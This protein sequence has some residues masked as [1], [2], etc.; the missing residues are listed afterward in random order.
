MPNS[1][2][3]GSIIIDTQLDTQGFEANSAELGKAIGSL[4]SQVD[5]LGP[6]FAQSLNGGVGSIQKFKDK[7]DGLKGTVS[8]LETE[9][10]A[11][12]NTRIPTD[13]Y[14]FIQ[15]QINKIDQ[16]LEKLQE[17]QAK[18]EATGVKQSSAA[19]KNLQYEIDLAKQKLDTYRSDAA[20]LENTGQAYKMGSDT[21]EYQQMADKLNQAKSALNEMNGAG[22][23]MHS[24]FTRVVS[25]FKQG[26]NVA[27][28][29]GSAMLRVGRTIGGAIHKG[30]SALVS[31]FKNMKTEVDGTRKKLLKMGL[32]LLG[33]RGLATGIR[34]IVN[35]ALN[36]NE[37][38]KNQLTALKGV[39]GQALSPA[40]SFLVGLLSKVVTLA[41][42]VYQIFTGTSLIAKYN[43]TQTK[44]AADGMADT[45]K[46]A[47]KA[48]RQLASF[49]SLNVLS[50]SNDSSKSSGGSSNDSESTP[51]KASKIKLNES[52]RDFFKALKKAIKKSDW[53]AVGALVA[54]GLNKALRKINW[55]K[56]KKTCKRIATKI[57]DFINAFVKKLDWGL[58]GKII[59]KAINTITVFVNTLAVKINWSRIGKSIAT[60]FK[61]MLNSINWELLGSTLASC[62]NIP[63]RIAENFAYTFNWGKFGKSIAST[64]RA[65][66][67][68]IDLQG[69][70]KA[71]TTGL[72]GIAKASQKLFTSP[73][74]TELGTKL[75][76][77][78]IIFFNNNPFGTVI[79]I[80]KNAL[81]GLMDAAIA[82]FKGGEV[83]EKFG[84]SVANGI[85]E[86]FCDGE[87]W[88][89]VGNLLSEVAKTVTKFAIAVI[90]N[91]NLKD[92][93]SAIAELLTNIDWWN[94]GAKIG[95]LIA[96]AILS[97][98]LAPA[99]WTG[100]IDD[101]TWKQWMSNLE[102][103]DDAKEQLFD[104]EKK[105]TIG[106]GSVDKNSFNVVNKILKKTKVS[107]QV[108]E[109]A[110]KKS[111][112]TV[113]SFREEL[114]KNKVS[115]ETMNKAL[116]ASGYS[117]KQVTSI[118]KNG[119]KEQKKALF[120]GLAS[121]KA[122]VVEGVKKT[123]KEIDKGIRIA[124]QKAKSGGKS[125]SKAAVDSANTELKSGK[126]TLT[127][128]T[129]ST[130]KTMISS[131]ISGAKSKKG[132]LKTSF[133]S[134]SDIANKA[135]GSA[136]F[137]TM[138]K[139]NVNK[140]VSGAKSVKGNVKSSF[141]SLSNIAN[142]A[143]G[144]APFGK[145]GTNAGNTFSTSVGST[146]DKAKSSGKDVGGNVI[147]G[148]IKGIEDA[149]DGFVKF[150]KEK[151]GGVINVAKTILGIHSPSTVFKAV[152]GFLMTGLKNG[153][154]GGAKS[155]VSSV[156]S[157]AGAITD[158]IKRGSYSITP[159][160]NNVGNVQLEMN[161]FTSV[162]SDGVTA[163]MDK[164]NYIAQHVTFRVPN[165]ALGTVVPYS[166]KGIPKGRNGGG[167]GGA[168]PY[169]DEELI[170][171]I[172]QAT[173]NQTTAII[174]ELQAQ[175][176]IPV[177]IDPKQMTTAVV[178][179]INRRTRATGKPQ[180]T[181]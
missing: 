136:P 14:K 162:I 82:L 12:G 122:F 157:V 2:A 167:Y 130:G 16:E 91:V 4:K 45:A 127:A 89:K 7:T 97:V 129:K 111:G 165:I 19:W 104:G 133:T 49:D 48:K 29:I 33:I 149:W 138:G 179:E 13:D 21:A 118:I 137:G 174:R 180:I 148:L 8:K 42:Q 41:D 60:G 102:V 83:G 84:K 153:I 166:V 128:T 39:I 56:I 77:T 87:W 61:S 106:I 9:L 120:D 18:M 68:T 134:L 117:W 103:P 81:A 101:N 141:T 177:Y 65:F 126:K 38:L 11:L 54:E 95:E 3:D 69:V 114:S 158:E 80:A 46:N 135:F 154:M 71:L 72:K 20:G 50:N 164:L 74:W 22:S 70:A 112:S 170:S 140:G 62:I 58:L 52:L 76:K 30:A 155:V 25:V 67:K 6:I 5:K 44:A 124:K 151:I 145:T 90:E 160:V 163:L 121:G 110:I 94:I 108:L 66:V 175:K 10:R 28:S 57:S 152:G 24:N 85:Q 23:R 169:N 181:I 150:W 139:S 131:G 55:G 96:K 17:K 107:Y 161:K 93:E 86:F 99:R 36:N 143:F 32:M 123:T 146:K 176:R 147:S 144:S 172:M 27:K 64:L 47:K 168:T 119:T 79:R 132:E 109:K 75:R 105:Q 115:V 92:I 1:Q 100:V 35:S 51:F 78:L 59:S 43:A 31:K 113:E 53:E 142:K 37:E 34:Q 116:K 156:A 171:V 159:T 98:V 173:S 63:I 40:I 15:D 26:Y 73:A 125:T 88:G 178:A